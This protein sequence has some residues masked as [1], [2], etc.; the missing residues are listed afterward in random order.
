M[1]KRYDYSGRVNPLG[2]LVTAHDYD[3]L[4]RQLKKVEDLLRTLYEEYPWGCSP[5]TREEVETYL[6]IE[7]EIPNEET[8]EAMEEARKMRK[9]D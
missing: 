3:E 2:T 8:R 4:E 5:G 6:G 1:V 9:D 7:P